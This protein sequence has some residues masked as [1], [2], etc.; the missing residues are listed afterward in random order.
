[1][2]VRKVLMLSVSLLVITLVSSL[3]V[4]R[5]MAQ[6]EGPSCTAK[7]TSAPQ[8]IYLPAQHRTMLPLVFDNRGVQLLPNT[9]QQITPADVP[10]STFEP[11]NPD[12]A[13]IQPVPG[14]RSPAW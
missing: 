14:K 10:G 6:C 5:I 3:G 7:P 11:L 13:T 9:G 12:L 1:M 4:M 2:N 8:S